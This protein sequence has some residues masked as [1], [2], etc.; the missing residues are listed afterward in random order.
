MIDDFH[1]STTIISETAKGKKRKIGHSKRCSFNDD[2]YNDKFNNNNK[3]NN[4]K[5]KKKDGINSRKKDLNTY[6]TTNTTSIVSL[7]ASS[8]SS[9]S[10]YSLFP[11]SLHSTI[12]FFK[13]QKIGGRII[14]KNNIKNH[15]LKSTHH[16]DNDIDNM[17]II[18]M[19][20]HL[21]K[22]KIYK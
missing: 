13:N 1:P 12:A 17:I 9:S 4:D 15:H 2:D 20:S 16:D 22:K 8:S 7:S 11:A 6:D 10:V 5:K 14:R 3:I 18:I 21:Y 19:N